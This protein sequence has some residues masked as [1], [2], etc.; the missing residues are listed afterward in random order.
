MKT[1]SNCATKT[2][3]VKKP[4]VCNKVRTV[5][6]APVPAVETTS[7]SPVNAQRNIVLTYRFEPGRDV[8]VVGTFNNWQPWDESMKMTDKE[9]D[10]V[11]SIT[12]RLK[13][14]SYEYKFFLV[15]DGKGDWS[16]DIQ[17]LERVPN[18]MGT[19]N[20]VLEIN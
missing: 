12:L 17:N 1:K 10:G 19:F 18:T 2:M 8:Y 13:P 14:G 5:K 16:E 9:N 20:S 4:R 3:A 7:D 11:Y 6:K 15:T